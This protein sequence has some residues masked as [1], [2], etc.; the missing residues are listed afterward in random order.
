MNIFKEAK[1][2]ELEGMEYCARHFKILWKNKEITWNWLGVEYGI[3]DSDRWQLFPIWNLS[4]N[5][6]RSLCFGIWKLYFQI[7]WFRKGSFNQ[8]RK[9]IFRKRFWKFYQLFT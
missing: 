9:F 6:Q 2:R 3:R 7:I 1:Q 8:D 4:H 5:C